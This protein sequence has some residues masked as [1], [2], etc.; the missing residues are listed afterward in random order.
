M[1][2]ISNTTKLFNL[3]K[4]FSWNSDSNDKFI[5]SLQSN[6][7]KSLLTDFELTSFECNKLGVNKAVTMFNNIIETAAKASLQITRP[8]N[9]KS[10]TSK[11]W[12]DN[13]CK[14]LRK[15]LKKTDNRLHKTQ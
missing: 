9:R 7:V 13:D 11:V 15:Q 12:F 1:N 3:P 4:P 10:K 2:K 8:K 14:I 6:Q 5:S